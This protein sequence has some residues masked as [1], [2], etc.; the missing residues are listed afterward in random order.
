MIDLAPW[1][2][3][4]EPTASVAI[5]D[6]ADVVV[7]SGDKLLGGPQA[8]LVLGKSEAVMKMRAHPLA[9]AVRVDKL[10]LAALEATLALYRDSAVAMRE[11]PALSMIAATRDEVEK[12]AR[13]LATAIAEN[14]VACSVGES[15]GAVGGGAFPTARL[16]SAAI[17]LDGDALRWDNALRAA[18]MP[19][20]G[21][22]TDDSYLLDVRTVMPDEES[23]LLESVRGSA[24]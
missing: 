12:R 19:V 20:V 7:M 23:F 8:G 2:L 11:I 21:R 5:A 1:G 16:A 4:G 3:A 6:G 10:T 14:G 18:R 13:A 15:E 22:I 9:R 24:L 17:R